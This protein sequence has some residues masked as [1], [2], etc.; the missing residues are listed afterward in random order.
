MYKVF[1]KEISKENEIV[2]TKINRVYT[3]I[4]KKNEKDRKLVNL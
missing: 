4:G 1:V 3:D 2:E